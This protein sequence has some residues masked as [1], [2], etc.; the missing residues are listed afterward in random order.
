MSTNFPA[1]LPH[2]RALRRKRRRKGT[3]L[4]P[5]FEIHCIVQTG[6]EGVHERLDSIGGALGP[7]FWRHAQQ[8]AIA[9]IEDKTFAYYV[10]R[11]DQKVHLVVA[12][13]PDGHKYLKTQ[14]DGEA[15]DHLLSLP[16]CFPDAVPEH[17][18]LLRAIPS[19]PR[20]LP[21]SLY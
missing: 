10:K 6:R 17:C 7:Y 20:W 5:E 21:S 11:G 13:S 16:E 18:S 4:R 1:S 14:A 12:V 15:P 9:W 19:A 3:S 2:E 8:Q